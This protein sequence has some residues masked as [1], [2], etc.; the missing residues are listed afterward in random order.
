M[1]FQWREGIKRFSPT[2]FIY[3]GELIM[4][5]CNDNTIRT[6]DNKCLTHVADLDDA[7]I[8]ADCTLGNIS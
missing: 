2:D 5:Q 3:D 4:R 7:T 1:D 8:I 6:L